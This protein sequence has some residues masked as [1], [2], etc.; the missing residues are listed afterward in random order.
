MNAYALDVEAADGAAEG[1]LYTPEGRGP[2]PGVIYLTDVWGIRPGNQGMALRLASQGYAVL[3]PNIFY[4]SDRLPIVQG[5]PD[6]AV[7]VTKALLDHLL[8]ALTP[9]MM[10]RDGPAYAD[11]LLRQP[12]V[13]GPKLAI[14]GYCFSGQFAVRTAGA[15]PDQIA[16]AASFHGGWLVTG[17]PDSPHTV[18]PRVK[19]ELYFGYAVEDPS[20][21]ASA[22]EQLDDAL[23]GW[24]G[25]YQSEM[26]EG[27]RHGWSV[28]GRPVYDP[29][30][31]ERHFQKLFALLRRSLG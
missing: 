28:P 14:V 1:F 4:R 27:A 22:I 17:K 19:A 6:P 10:L 31:S 18:L 5:E 24:G 3:M 12:Q 9:E 20:M 7:P 26:Y 2:W 21:P 11:F 25:R 8:G 15:A 30:Q 29:L 16:A 23:K 13:R